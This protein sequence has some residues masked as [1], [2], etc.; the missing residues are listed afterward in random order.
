ML[1][2]SVRSRKHVASCYFV[3]GAIGLFAG[4]VLRWAS[5]QQTSDDP[6]PLEAVGEEAFNAIVWFYDYDYDATIPLTSR[7]VERTDSNISIREEIVFR[8]VRGFLV[9]GFLELPM[10]R[11]APSPL[12]LLLHGWSGSKESWWKDGGYISGGNMR[13]GLLAATTTVV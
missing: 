9:S 6:P 3:L 8:G 5:A 12:V 1:A 2:L 7:I 4:P 10:E 11:A 13:K